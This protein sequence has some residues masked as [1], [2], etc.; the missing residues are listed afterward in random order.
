M[1][2][3]VIFF[4]EGRNSPKNKVVLVNETIGNVLKM[5]GA[6]NINHSYLLSEG[7]PTEAYSYYKFKGLGIIATFLKFNNKECTLSVNFS[8]FEENPDTLNK[9]KMYLKYTFKKFLY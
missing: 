5:L 9:L 1:N 7:F 4:A 3:E 2:Q 8:G 6:M